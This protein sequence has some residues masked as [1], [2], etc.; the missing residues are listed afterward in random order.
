MRPHH[1]QAARSTLHPHAHAQRSSTGTGDHTA[2]PPT[3]RHATSAPSLPRVV[4]GRRRALPSAWREPNQ[5]GRTHVEKGWSGRFV[6]KESETQLKPRTGWFNTA[7][8]LANVSNSQSGRSQSSPTQTIRARSPRPPSNSGS[9]YLRAPVHPTIHR[10]RSAPRPTRVHVPVPA[11]PVR[12]SPVVQPSLVVCRSAS[13]LGSSS[14]VMT[15]A[16]VGSGRAR[17][18]AKSVSRTRGDEN[19]HDEEEEEG[20][21]GP[22]LAPEYTPTDGLPISPSRPIIRPQ[23]S[24]GFLRRRPS[25]SPHTSHQIEDE[26]DLASIISAFRPPSAPA[27]PTRRQRSIRSLR[28]LL[29][30]PRFP[31]VPVVCVASPGTVCAGG[32]GRAVWMSGRGWEEEVGRKNVMSGR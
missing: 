23:R 18:K 27:S 13:N 6:V 1:A 25:P 14:S 20:E 4:S 29:K 31:D 22:V 11:P 17:Q 24:T 19:V 26:P 3:L 16:S 12:P 9:M 5:E 32:P 28:A 10:A 7:R 15:R 8:P 2:A 30:D 21:A